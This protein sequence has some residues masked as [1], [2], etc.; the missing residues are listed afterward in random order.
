MKNGCLGSRFFCYVT[1]NCGLSMSAFIVSSDTVIPGTAGNDFP[2]LP[3][4]TS[5][6]GGH[7]Y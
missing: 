7:P 2:A 5:R 1:V 4:M 3:E 6:E